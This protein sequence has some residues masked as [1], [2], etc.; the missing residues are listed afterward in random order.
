MNLRM[1]RA[2]LAG[3]RDDVFYIRDRDSPF[4]Q[5]RRVS[6]SRTISVCESERNDGNEKTSYIGIIVLLEKSKELERRRD[7]H[8]S[9]SRAQGERPRVEEE[10]RRMT[11]ERDTIESA[12]EASEDPDDE[13]SRRTYFQPQRPRGSCRRVRSDSFLF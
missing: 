8:L 12:A 2:S 6:A 7:E 9:R 4:R 5:I 11:I 1:K 13:P 10:G 3:L